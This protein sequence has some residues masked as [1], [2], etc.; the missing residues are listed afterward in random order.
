M[1]SSTR[2]DVGDVPAA[3]HTAAAAAMPARPAILDDTLV[4]AGRSI[5]VVSRTPAAV[6]SATFMP[7]ILLLVMTASFSKVV[8]PGGSYGDYVNHVLPL[9]AVMGMIFSS[10]TTGVA[11]HR[12]LH[13]GMDNRLRTLPVA[14]SAPLVGRIVGDATRNLLTLVVLGGVGVALGF[15]FRA[16]MVPAL[17]TVGLALVFGFAFACIAVA[18]AARA[19]SAEAMVSALNGLLLVLSFLSNGFVDTDDLPGWAQPVATLN[20]VSSVVDA[21]RALTQ[22][23]ATTGPVLEALAW[24]IGLSAVFGS[25]AVVAYRR[26]H[27]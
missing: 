7:I 23:G 19:S 16:G 3:S 18:V 8:L 24:S 17:S 25:L 20:P 6:L 12:D 1:S 5:R 13:S 2:S 10:V 11:A 22:G 4:M 15:R 26:T 27:R 21:M 9:F 14:S